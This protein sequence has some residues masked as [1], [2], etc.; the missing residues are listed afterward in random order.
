MLKK[1]HL[2]D[3]RGAGRPR[4]QGLGLRGQ[5]PGW[6]P[7]CSPWGRLREGRGPAGRT[8]KTRRKLLPVLRRRPDHSQPGLSLPARQVLNSQRGCAPGGILLFW[9]L[10]VGNDDD[11]GD[12]QTNPGKIKQRPIRPPGLT[13]GETGNLS[14]NS[15]T[16]LFSPC[17]QLRTHRQGSTL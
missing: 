1:P 9:P 12:A 7:G 13:P 15:P 8:G 5:A 6:L 17:C 11:D 2:P 14:V 10:R 16:D 4:A 3:G